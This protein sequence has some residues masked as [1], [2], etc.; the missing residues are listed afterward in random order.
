[1]RSFCVLTRGCIKPDPIPLNGRDDV[2]HVLSLLQLPYHFEKFLLC[3]G[4]AQIVN[5]GEYGASSSFKG[6]EKLKLS[7]IRTHYEVLLRK[8][9]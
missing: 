3:K 9:R 6:S 4:V 8:L 2:G 7:G 5:K 1:M